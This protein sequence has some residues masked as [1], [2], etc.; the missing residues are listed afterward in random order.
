[1]SADA[2]DLLTK[3]LVKQPEK[4][5]PLDQVLKHPFLTKNL[6]EEELLS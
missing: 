5:L 6:S 1:V 4:R 2:R 3:L